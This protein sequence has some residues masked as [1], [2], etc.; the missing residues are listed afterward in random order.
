MKVL[1]ILVSFFSFI[2]ASVDIN[3]ANV[4]EFTTL[5][6]IGKNKANSILEYRK[7]NCFKS[8]N[9]LIKVKGIGKKILEKNKEN[10]TIS[11]CEK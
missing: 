3:K 2:F 11:E 9:E 4:K 6:G 7:K 5:K 8:I 10:L 1:F